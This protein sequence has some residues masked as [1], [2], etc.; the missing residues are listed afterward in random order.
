MTQDQVLR[1]DRALYPESPLWTENQH[2]KRASGAAKG[3]EVSGYLMCAPSHLPV[4]LSIDTHV[5][6]QHRHDHTEHMRPHRAYM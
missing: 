5:L 6:S 3:C 2:L 4:E 1:V